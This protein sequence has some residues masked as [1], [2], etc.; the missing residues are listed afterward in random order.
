MTRARLSFRSTQWIGVITV[1]L[2]AFAFASPSAKAQTAEF[3]QNSKNSN[4]MTLEVPLSNYPGRGINLPITL[5]YS[6]SGLWRIG[7]INSVYA[8]VP[9]YGSVRRSVTEAIYAEHS[10]RDGQ[11]V[12]TL[13]KSNGRNRTTF[14]GLT[15]NPIREATCTRTRFVW[16]AFSF[17]CPMARPTNFA[18]RIRFTAHR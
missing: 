12:S 9:G 5:H 2:M 10:R 13:Q 11:P 18:K 7:F 16:P 15:A 6:S 3:T 4:S 14:I 8:N 1:G 17:T